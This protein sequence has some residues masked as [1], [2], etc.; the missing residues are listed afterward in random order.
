MEVIDKTGAL[1]QIDEIFKYK[2][3]IDREDR[4]V[5]KAIINKEDEKS[6]AFYNRFLDMVIDE[7][8]HKLNKTEFADLRNELV[9]EMKSHLGN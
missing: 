1:F 9:A 2:D 7:A 5:L 4:E 8:D 3:L 6:L